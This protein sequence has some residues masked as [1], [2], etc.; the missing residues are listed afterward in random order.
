MS[1]SFSDV[2]W[3][4][5]H[6]SHANKFASAENV[7]IRQLATNQELRDLVLREIIP[8]LNIVGGEKGSVEFFVSIR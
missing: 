8:F 7:N 4:S 2:S 3:M 6:N 5:S 1:F